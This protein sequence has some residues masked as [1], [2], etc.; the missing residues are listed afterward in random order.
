MAEFTSPQTPLLKREGLINPS[1]A[2]GAGTPFLKGDLYT[3]EKPDGLSE[4]EWAVCVNNPA[5]VFFDEFAYNPYLVER[6][7]RES[8]R[9]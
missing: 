4:E 1:P 3:F 6:E 9:G 5:S 2:Q 8:S 7:M